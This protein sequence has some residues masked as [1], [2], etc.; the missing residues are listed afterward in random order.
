MSSV[1]EPLGATTP[2]IPV[3]SLS[4]ESRFIGRSLVPTSIE[5]SVD[6]WSSESTSMGV[7]FTILWIVFFPPRFSGDIPASE[8]MLTGVGFSI[9]WIVFLP[10]R[11]IG[12]TPLL[13]CRGGGATVRARNQT[14]VSEFAAINIFRS[15]LQCRR[16]AGEFGLF[17]FMF[18]RRFPPTNLP[19]AIL[20]ILASRSVIRSCHFLLPSAPLDTRCNALPRGS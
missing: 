4:T 8:S 5:D 7:G 10:L 12:D 17:S 1:F 6:P 18:G 3:D 15:R 16:H 19:C 20:I 14:R 9:L 11:F 13:F 2:V